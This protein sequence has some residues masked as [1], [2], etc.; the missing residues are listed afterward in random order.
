MS[1]D[2]ALGD[3]V[4]QAP[5]NDEAKRHNSNLPGM[6]GLFNTVNLNLYHLCEVNLVE[7]KMKLSEINNNPLAN[8]RKLRYSKLSDEKKKKIDKLNDMLISEYQLKVIKRKRNY[9]EIGDIFQINPKNNIFYYGVVINNHIHNKNGDDLILILI[10]D[11][12]EDIHKKIEKKI[13]KNDL[14]ISP[15]IVGKEYWTRGYFYTVDHI[16]KKVEI[17]SFGFYGIL[18]GFY[19]DEYQ[20]RLDFEPEIKSMGGVNT[21]SGIAYEMNIEMII[22]E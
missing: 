9:P 1:T 12:N 13:T 15:T 19:Y 16:E 5:I 3:D 6:D 18:D 7:N 20:N 14:L 2:P 11:K 21:I 4:P 8:A 10:F 17:E 22:R